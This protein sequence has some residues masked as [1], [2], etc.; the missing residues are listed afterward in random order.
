MRILIKRDRH[1]LPIPLI[2]PSKAKSD[3]KNGLSC[4]FFNLKEGQ[5]LAISEI[6]QNTFLKTY[7]RFAD[8]STFVMPISRLEKYSIDLLLPRPS[9]RVIKVTGTSQGKSKNSR[10]RWAVMHT[11]SPNL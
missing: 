10:G 4:H 8:D 2:S 5:Q 1:I 6:K 7:H 11:R 3:F 9:N